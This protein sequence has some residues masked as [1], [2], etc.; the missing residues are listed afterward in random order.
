[1]TGGL[2]SRRRLY[3]CVWT[4]GAQILVVDRRAAGLPVRHE[5]VSGN[6]ATPLPA[7]PL[8]KTF[9]IE[10]RCVEH[11][12]RLAG[13]SSGTFCGR[14]QRCAETSSTRRSA[15]EHLGDLAPV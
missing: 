4:S 15:H 8:V 1:M 13:I 6:V 3:E 14:K 10:A 9:S 11:E 5:C 12:Q 2:R 7:A